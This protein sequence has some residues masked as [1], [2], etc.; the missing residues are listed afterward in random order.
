M[1]LSPRQV[2]PSSWDN[3]LAANVFRLTSSAATVLGRRIVS[4]G[5]GLRFRRIPANP[6]SMRAMD[7]MAT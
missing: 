6:Y 7:L 4:P 5:G 2:A 3:V 1:R